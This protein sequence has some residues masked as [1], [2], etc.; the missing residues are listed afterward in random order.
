MATT[1]DEKFLSTAQEGI[2]LRIALTRYFMLTQ[3]EPELFFR[4][5]AYLKRRVR[6][7]AGLLIE[8]DDADRLEVLCSK[9]WLTMEAMDA[10]IDIASKQE[11]IQCLTCLMQNRAASFS[12]QDRD[13]TL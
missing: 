9:G 2:K 5:E 11:K 6:S 4:Y 10:L 1:E 13:F 8:S 12:L 7:A 3:D